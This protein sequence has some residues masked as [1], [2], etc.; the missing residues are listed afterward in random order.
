MY[1]LACRYYITNWLNEKSDVYSYGVV[2]LEIITN[3]PAILKTHERIHISQW[4]SDL[5]SKGDINSIV[6]PMLEGNFDVNSVW[7]AVEIAMACVSSSP[8]ERPTMS[9]VLQVLKECL[10]TELAH[11]KHDYDKSTNI[12]EMESLNFSTELIRIPIAR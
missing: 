5:L 3:R 10:A 6:D 1:G 7:K 9:E 2:L 12:G 11:T 4:V 8:T